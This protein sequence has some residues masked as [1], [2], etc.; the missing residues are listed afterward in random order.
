MAT[1]KHGAG[2]AGS[3]SLTV[4]V[5]ADADLTQQPGGANP[6]RDQGI[7]SVYVTNRGTVDLTVQPDTAGAAPVAEADDLS[8]L[9]PGE[10]RELAVPQAAGV[11]TN[12]VA[13]RSIAASACPWSVE[14]GRTR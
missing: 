1:I 2:G 8:V 7:L 14:V 6:D 9:V 10:R 12:S 4:A 11:I 5:A 3:Q 13:V